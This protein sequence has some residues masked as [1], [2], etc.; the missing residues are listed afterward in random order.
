M[1]AEVTRDAADRRTVRYGLL[2]RVVRAR[3]ELECGQPTDYDE[4][5]AALASLEGCAGL[6]AWRVTA[7]LAA[8][9]GQDR[10]WRDAERRAG[11]LVIRAGDHAETLRRHV[12]ATFA[13]LGEWC[14]SRA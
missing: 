8:T 4:I 3:A 14:R 6:E 2:A 11:A 13:A 5:D 1:A 10:W 7:E 9:A 12:A